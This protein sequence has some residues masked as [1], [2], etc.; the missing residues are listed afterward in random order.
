MK[1]ITSFL[2]IFVFILLSGYT[3]L[4]NFASATSQEDFIQNLYK[5]YLSQ[6]DTAYWFDNEKKLLKYFDPILTELFL[7]DEKCK[8][9][10]QG[11]CN[12]DFD[13]I[14]DAQDL[15]NKYPVTLEVITLNSKDQNRCQ[16]IFTNITQRTI[17]YELK[18][19]KNGLRISDIIY[20]DGQSLR[21]I[22]KGKD[23]QH[24]LN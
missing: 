22:L 4:L 20:S 12:L 17:I 5:E 16:V 3:H 23:V 1:H 13:P 19:T 14:I 7:R 15:D 8:E 10:T 6:Y 21:N 11:I 24:V 9:E 18:Q 2:A